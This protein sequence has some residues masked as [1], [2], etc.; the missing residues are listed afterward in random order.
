MSGKNSEQSVN[1]LKPGD[2]V[3]MEKKVSLLEVN[4]LKLERC[5]ETI[6]YETETETKDLYKG[7]SLLH[8][9][10]LTGRQIISGTIHSKRKRSK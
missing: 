10:V 4:P 7:E 8:R 2:L 6:P 5:L 1:N 3:N 9:K